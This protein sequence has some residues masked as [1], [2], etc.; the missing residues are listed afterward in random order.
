MESASIF[1]A[2]KALLIVSAGLGFLLIIVLCML[3]FTNRRSQRV[4]QSLLMLMTR[5]ER[6]KI[7]DA[8]RMLQTLLGEEM[9]KLDAGFQSIRDSLQRQ[10]DSANELKREL[11]VQN[12]QLVTTAD[13]AT[14]KMVQMSQRLDNTLSGLREIV[15]SES[16]NGVSSITDN[17]AGAVG[18]LLERIDATSRD[19]TD[20]VGQIQEQIDGWIASGQTLSDALKSEFESNAAQMENI[21]ANATTMQT[22][23]AEVAR[24]TTEGFESVKTSSAGYAEIMGENKKMLDDHLKKLDTYTKQSSKQL[25]T[26]LSQLKGTADAVAG[27]IRL[28]ETYIEQQVNTLRASCKDTYEFSDSL[29][30]TVRNITTELVNLNKFFN[31]EIKEFTNGVVTELQTVTGVANSTLE[32]TKTAAGAFSESVRTMATEVRETLIEMDTAHTQLSGQSEA[33]IKMSEDTTAKLQPLSELIE[34][35]YAALPDLSRDSAVAGETLDKIVSNLNEKI[36][37]MRATVSESTESIGVSA[38]K[39]E[40]FA[41]QSRQQMIDLMSDYAKA[42][43]TMQT[44]NKQM[45]VARASAPMDAIKTAPATQYG[46][47]SGSDFLKQSERVFEK[48]HELS[49]DLMRATGAEIPDAVWNKYHAGDMTIFSK[50]LAKVLDAADKKQVRER[51]KSDSVFRSQAMQFVRSYGKILAT[52][53]QTDSS[54]TVMAALAKTD[55]GK[56]YSALKAQL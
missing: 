42:V 41:G 52:A 47:V 18:G 26:Q 14:K 33:L 20:R 39:L 29:T 21:T 48:L 30:N 24:T 51:L 35:Y 53:Q 34:R 40:D 4:M 23:I 27:Q 37:L 1:F 12:E 55:L 6:A 43:D 19:A 49:M 38:L 28:S 9:A 2:D 54:D 32:K 16:W 44:L 15:D 11:T 31:K 22:Q 13:D 56:I 45:M 25:Q 3:F 8:T 36:A 46:R 17:F 10:I 50:W 5:P 7:Q